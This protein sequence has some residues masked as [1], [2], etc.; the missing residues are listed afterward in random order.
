M[1]KSAW[2]SLLARVGFGQ[3]EGDPVSAATAPAVQERLVEAVGTQSEDEA[4][5]TRLT[6]DG[7]GRYNQRDLTP[8]NQ[9][10][11]AKLAEFLW[12]SNTLANRLIE[13]PL[14]YLTAEGVSLQC[15]HPE[16]Q[17]LLDAFWNDPINNWPL[18]LPARVRALALLGEQCYVINA[19]SGNGFVRLGY[20]DPRQIGQVVM[21]PDNPEQAIGVITKRDARGKYWK[22]RVAVLGDDPELFSA[23]TAKI[24]AEDF[25]DGECLLYQVNKFPDGSRGRSDL[26][27]QM[28]WLDAYDNFLFDEIDRISFLRRFVWDVTLKGADP[29]MVKKF[30]KEFKAPEPNSKFVH[31]DSVT[32]QAV[33]PTLQAADTSESARLLRNHVLG[34]ATVPEH[35]FGGGGDVNRAAASEM[36]EPTFKI[37]TARQSMLKIMLEEIGRLVLWKATSTNEPNWGD[38]KWKVTAVFPELANKDLTKFAAAMSQVATTVVLLID[39]GLLTQERGLSLIA[40]V[41]GRFGQ[42]IDAADELAKARLEHEQRKKD[43]AAADSFNLPADLRDALKDGK[44]GASPAP[45]PGEPAASV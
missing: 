31:N 11:M 23:R 8:M 45:A 7:L 44:A 26:L 28:D 38:E 43:R 37:Y 41:A 25:T 14:A 12:Q 42:Q 2:G 24:R 33:S 4:G 18:K 22:Y 9:E 32:L 15:E 21:D 10:R 39:N 30:D 36:G 5:W 40:D 19:N 13:L 16:H 3:L 20:L 17:K 27:G 34:G 1:I 6:G 29:E 35:W